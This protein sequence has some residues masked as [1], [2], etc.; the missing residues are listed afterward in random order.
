M[1]R[2]V[3]ESVFNSHFPGQLGAGRSTHSVES[4]HTGSAAGDIAFHR[5]RSAVRQNSEGVG[6]L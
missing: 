2:E 6:T 3:G 5:I 1:S 4:Y